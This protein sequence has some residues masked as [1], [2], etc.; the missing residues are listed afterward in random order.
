MTLKIITIVCSVVL[1]VKSVYDII[2]IV[3]PEK[4]KK[5]K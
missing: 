5:K 2:C 4:G 1:L 3:K